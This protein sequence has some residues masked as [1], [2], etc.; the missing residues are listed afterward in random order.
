MFLEA[1]ARIAGELENEG[2]KYAKS[3]PH[4]TRRNGD[5]TFK[6]WFQSSHNNIADQLVCLWIHATV[7]SGKIKKWR[8][9]QVPPVSDYSYVAGGQIGNLLSNTS[10]ME[11][12]LA[13]PIRR[14]SVVADA[15]ATIQRIA[16]PYFSFFDQPIELRDTLVERDLPS[17]DIA[18]AIE[19]LICFHGIEYAQRAL[20]RFLNHRQDLLGDFWRLYR[21]FGDAGLPPRKSSGFAFSLAYLAVQQNI[22]VNGVTST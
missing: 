20:V 2:F 4:V 10:W 21:E 19:Y 17:M 15:V 3:G 6:V 8:A 16:I 18:R 9:Q 12:D 1:T 13:N 11:W 7:L 14:D 5:L 22:G